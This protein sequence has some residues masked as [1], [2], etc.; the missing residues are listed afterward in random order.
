M[1]REAQARIVSICQSELPLKRG[2]ISRYSTK[3][4]AGNDDMNFNQKEAASSGEEYD[5]DDEDK[6][7]KSIP[8]ND[9]LMLSFGNLC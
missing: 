9:S 4:Q 3:P 6:S 8:T 5:E 2:G 7:Q 1:W